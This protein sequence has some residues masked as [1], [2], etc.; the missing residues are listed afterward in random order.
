MRILD[1]ESRL[2]EAFVN[3]SIPDTDKMEK[4]DWKPFI[5]TYSR[6]GDVIWTFPH[7]GRNPDFVQDELLY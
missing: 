7:E 5:P 4:D 3:I 1:K 6:L 2:R